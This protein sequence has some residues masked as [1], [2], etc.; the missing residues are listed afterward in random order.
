MCALMRVPWQREACQWGEQGKQGDLGG[1]THLA[2]ADLDVEDHEATRVLRTD[3]MKAPNLDLQYTKNV[4]CEG[5][6]QELGAARLGQRRCSG[7]PSDPPTARRTAAGVI[8][9]VMC[10]VG[11]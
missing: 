4:S 7:A 2:R 8:R 6:Q 3:W 5:E 10:C 11:Q 9:S 1:R